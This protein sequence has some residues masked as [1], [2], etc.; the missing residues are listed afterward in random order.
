MNAFSQLL[1][2]RPFDATDLYF[3]ITNVRGTTHQSVELDEAYLAR[4]IDW[5]TDKRR[6]YN[7][8]RI[9]FRPPVEVRSIASVVETCLLLAF[10]LSGKEAREQTWIEFLDAISLLQVLNLT[11][12]PEKSRTAV[13]LNL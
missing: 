7:Y 5:R 2:D 6:V 13:L 3:K 9:Y 1:T 4:P 12:L 8:R 10:Q 11:E